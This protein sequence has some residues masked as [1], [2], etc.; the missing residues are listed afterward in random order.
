MIGHRSRL[1][2]RTLL[3]FGVGFWL[4]AQCVLSSEANEKLTEAEFQELHQQLQPP[5][6]ELWRTIPWQVSLLE[7]R[8][9]AAR[10]KKPLVMRVRA[11]HPLG[12]V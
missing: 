12:C 11:G 8:E 3:P 7:A 6:D 2:L 10:E 1:C 5:R 9:L 4:A